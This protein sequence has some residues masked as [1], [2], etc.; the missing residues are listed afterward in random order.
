MKRN[1]CIACLVLVVGSSVALAQTPAPAPPSGQKTLAATLNVSAFPQKGQSATQQSQDESACYQWAVQNTGKDPFEL[2]KQAQQQAQQAEAAKSQVA[3]S[4]KGAGAKGAVKG[5]AAG[6]VV[7][8]IA[9]DDA[10]KGAG[11]GAA[12]GAVAGRRKG[13]KAEAE[14]T[15]QI[16]QQAQAQQAAT[17]QDMTNFKKAFTACLEGKG[18]IAKF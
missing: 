15:K 18:Y 8:E 11:V 12:A 16:D 13:K 9:N 4:S 6:A 2:Q 1:L 14:A 3:G 10:G 17:S 7:G 5:A